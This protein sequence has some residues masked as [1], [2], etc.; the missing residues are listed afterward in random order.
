MR[1]P[2]R[3]RHRRLRA[4]G[5][6]VPERLPTSANQF[7]ALVSFHYNTGA[8]RRSTLGALHKAGRF[9]E[10]RAEFGRWIHNNGKPMK[11]LQNRRREEAELYGTA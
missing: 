10:A 8:I 7:D 3:T 9:A 2:V 11:G 4:R 6:G 1:C 5:G